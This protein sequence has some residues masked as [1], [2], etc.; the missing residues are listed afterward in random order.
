MR[1]GPV[2]DARVAEA[3]A[4]AH[5]QDD[6]TQNHTEQA[7]QLIL[8]SDIGNEIRNLQQ[9]QRLSVGPEHEG[10]RSFCRQWSQQCIQRTLSKH[11]P[12]SNSTWSLHTRSC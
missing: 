4:N 6:T 8:G 12:T 9:Q 5:V 7:E 11:L 10:Y 1:V 3:V 2:K